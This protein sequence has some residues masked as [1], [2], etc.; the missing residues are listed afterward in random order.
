MTRFGRQRFRGKTRTTTSI[1]RAV[2]FRCVANYTGGLAVPSRGL[3]NVMLLAGWRSDLSPFLLSWQLG[4]REWQARK[5][6][7]HSVWGNGPRF[8]ERRR[9]RRGDGRGGG[10]SGRSLADSPPTSN[11]ARERG[12]HKDGAEAGADEGRHRGDPPFVF[13]PS[14]FI[15]PWSPQIVSRGGLEW[16][17]IL[18]P[19]RFPLVLLWVVNQVGERRQQGPNALSEAF[20]TTNN[21]KREPGLSSVRVCPVKQTRWR[22]VISFFSDVCVCVCA[23]LAA[24]LFHRV[25]F[26]IC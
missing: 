23:R 1:G 26:M 6:S 25:V 21:P 16:G 7:R 5:A 4:K 18:S 2:C 22:N 14:V 9:V 17:R 15:C 24:E 11:G 10:A 19:P 3:S 20:R 12:V 13:V 8:S